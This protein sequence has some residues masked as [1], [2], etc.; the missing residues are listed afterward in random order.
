MVYDPLMEPLNEDLD[1]EIV[2]TVDELLVQTG[3]EDFKN[4]WHADF[5]QYALDTR[6]GERLFEIAKT[7]TRVRHCLFTI[8]SAQ[9]KAL[10]DIN[11]G[12]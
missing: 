12:T 11:A 3:G 8:L 7:D 9:E 10:Q 5:V 2:S 4:A 1:A 6:E